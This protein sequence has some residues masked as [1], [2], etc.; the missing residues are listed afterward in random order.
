M[1]RARSKPARGTRA[2]AQFGAAAQRCEPRRPGGAPRAAKPQPMSPAA[3]THRHGVRCSVAPRRVT[4]QSAAAHGALGRGPHLCRPVHVH[5]CGR[6]ARF[7]A[8]FWP[9]PACWLAR[10]QQGF[11]SGFYRL[12]DPCNHYG[13]VYLRV[14]GSLA[15]LQGRR[16]PCAGD[17]RRWVDGWSPARSRRAAAWAAGAA[18]R[19]QC[20][21]APKQCTVTSPCHAWAATQPT[22]GPC[23]LH[24]GRRRERES[25]KRRLVFQGGVRGRLRSVHSKATRA[26]PHTS[27]VPVTRWPGTGAWPRAAGSCATARAPEQARPATAFL[28]CQS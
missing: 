3:A 1:S 19:K 27:H 24:V 15:S 16:A 2:A 20:T 18:G 13:R 22:H 12:P 21:P 28:T 26:P 6:V 14:E 7:A 11:G 4:I 17:S 10:R 23:L 25:S 5:A 8:V 9:G